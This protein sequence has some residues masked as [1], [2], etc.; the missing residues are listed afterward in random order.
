MY[1][2][3]SV[4]QE[5]IYVYEHLSS[6][7]E[8]LSDYIQLFFNND[9]I[10]SGVYYGNAEYISFVADIKFKTENDNHYLNFSLTKYR[11]TFEKVFPYKKLDFINSECLSN[12]I[13]KDD[14]FSGYI[15]DD[16]LDLYWG[17]LFFENNNFR[18]FFKLLK[19]G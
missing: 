18:M 3:K 16:G 6:R 9:T 13:Y 2:S 15:K 4:A 5:K 19:T 14:N 7:G 10:V 17:R 1:Q 11:Y 12:Q 8:K